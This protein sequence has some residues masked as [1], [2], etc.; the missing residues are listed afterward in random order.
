MDHDEG[1]RLLVDDHDVTREEDVINK[2]RVT[3][4]QVVERPGLD[5]KGSHPLGETGFGDDDEESMLRHPNLGPEIG[6]DL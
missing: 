3:S 6:D 2:V 4:D 1:L 5:K